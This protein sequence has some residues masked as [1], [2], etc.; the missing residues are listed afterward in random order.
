MTARKA[1]PTPSTAPR[2]TAHSKRKARAHAKTAAA[3]QAETAELNA[4]PLRNRQAAGIDIGSRS[5]WVCVGFATAEHSDLVREFPAHTDGLHA[6]AAYLHEHGVTSVALESTGIYWIPLYELLESE[7]LEVFLVDPS[8]TKQIK[9]RPKTDKR[10]AQWIY[11]LHSV[12]LLA[13]AFRPD[14]DTCVLRSYL[15]QRA[16]L[17]RYASQHIQHLH[18]ALEQMNLKLNNVLSSLTGST[19]QQI[20]RAILR[21]TRD[22]QKLAA[23]RNYRCQATVAEIAQAL[24]GSY[25]PEHLFALRQAFEGWQFYQKQVD[26]VDEQLRQQLERMKTT[27]ALPPLPP[28]TRTRGR[29]PNDP[30]FDVRAALYYVVGLDLLEIEGLD[31]GTALVVVGELGTDLSKFA[32]VKHFCSWLGLCPQFRKTGGKVQSSRTRPGMNRVAAALRLAAQG[33][34]HSHSAL[35][36]YYRRQKSRLGPPKANTATAHKLA[37][38]LYYALTKG[39]PY[40]KQSQAEYEAQL[41]AKQVEALKKKARRL[42]LEVQEKNSGSGA[43]ACA[44]SPTGP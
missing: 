20:I 16:N 36:A 19:G 28:K 24:T 39:L 6:L 44:P 32:T 8:Y 29:K 30:R 14:G 5:H 2:T 9:G 23:L 31:E 7:G 18:K 42:G 12:G 21:G 15:R 3:R 38:L 33:L 22:P 11:R 34:H 43:A 41:R 1:K 13:A 37:R 25:R 27:R 40:V 10:D 17:I 4:L 26:A 35:G